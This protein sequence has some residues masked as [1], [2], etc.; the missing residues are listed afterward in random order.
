[1]RRKLKY[2]GKAV[3]RHIANRINGKS[4]DYQ[5]LTHRVLT[6]LY[7]KHHREDFNI[8][9][10]ENGRDQVICTNGTEGV[11]SSL[12]DRDFI[13]EQHHDLD[14]ENWPFPKEIESMIFK[15][16]SEYLEHLIVDEYEGDPQLQDGQTVEEHPDSDDDDDDDIDDS[17]KLTFSMSE[18]AP[19]NDIEGE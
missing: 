10:S 4:K 8:I 1:M 9:P 2:K 17:E 18:G 15:E 3:G 13:T 5:E 16:D 7:I 12:D 6:R 11:V 14:T 19:D